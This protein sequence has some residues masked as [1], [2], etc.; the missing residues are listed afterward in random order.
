MSAPQLFDRALLADEPGVQRFLATAPADV[1]ATL[2][3]WLDEAGSVSRTADRLSVH[4]QTVYHRL[5]Q[6]ER[7]TGHDLARG[8]DRLSLHLA[9]ELAPFLAEPAPALRPPGRGAAP[10]R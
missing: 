9:V 1:V 2:R 5:A 10:P 3:T 8:R 6:V 4:R 7:A